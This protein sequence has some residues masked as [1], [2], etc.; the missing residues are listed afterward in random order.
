MSEEIRKTLLNLKA[1]GSI[2]SKVAHIRAE[3]KRLEDEL[4]EKKKTL[5]AAEK[6]AAEKISHHAERSRMYQR[7][8]NFLRDEQA[9]LVDRRK[10]LQSLQSYKLQQA[11]EKEIEAASKQ[12]SAQEENL[13]E[14]L[15]LVESLE[16]TA[17]EA[18]GVLDGL[19][20]E[21]EALSTEAEE[22]FKTLEERAAAQSTERAELVAAI[23]PKAF[24]QYERLAE[25]F[26]MDTVV[27]FKNN[28]CTG[29]FLNLG[30]QTMVQI[31]RAEE[32]IRC[33][34]CGRILYLGE[35]EE[36]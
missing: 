2:D 24:K 14:A 32:I 26:P 21:Y 1:I 33:R 20:S 16:K 35:S 4:A 23:D 30:P 6:D 18:Q 11:A 27:A 17:Q 34:G 7:E 15:D 19:K 5:D 3:R 9:K 29:C 22:T 10:A 36:E 12:L 8:E 28:T 25:R 13:I 31:G